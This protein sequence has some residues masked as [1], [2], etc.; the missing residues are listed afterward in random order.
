MWCRQ[1]KADAQTQVNFNLSHPILRELQTISG[2]D[3]AN[4]D[5]RLGTR[6][7]ATMQIK[8]FRQQKCE[9]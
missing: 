4:S 3:I 5:A 9:A 8:R 6:C 2:T 1:D 7:S